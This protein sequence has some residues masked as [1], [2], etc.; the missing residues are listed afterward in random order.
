MICCQKT[1]GCER[2]TGTLLLVYIA[3]Q[4]R[5]LSSF[6]SFSFFMFHPYCLIQRVRLPFSLFTNF[7]CWKL[8]A[9]VDLLAKFL[10]RVTFLKIVTS[11][12]C[13]C[14]RKIVRKLVLKIT[15]YKAHQALYNDGGGG[16]FFSHTMI[17][18]KIFN[19]TI[20]ACP[21]ILNGHHLAHTIFT[22]YARN[23]PQWP[24]DDCGRA[25][26][27]ELCVSSFS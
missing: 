12:Q 13:L 6:F 15:S 22:L 24:R 19:N 23:S 3:K 8:G 2:K 11:W 18:G 5:Q 17:R 10:L 7:L 16:G 21:F 9:C 4:Y 26:P 1:T 27:Y 14:G 25:F 20:P